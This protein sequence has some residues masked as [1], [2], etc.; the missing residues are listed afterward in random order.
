MR[1][2]GSSVYQ[3]VGHTTYV[4]LV[5]HLGYPVPERVREASRIHNAAR[6]ARH[7]R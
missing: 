1:R 6:R 4:R 7:R 5:E 3:R 2:L